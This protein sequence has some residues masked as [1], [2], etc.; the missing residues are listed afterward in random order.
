MF[1]MSDHDL[2][3]LH[4]ATLFTHNQRGD[5]VTVNDS[6]MAPAP[7]FFMGITRHGAVRRFRDDVDNATRAALSELAD[8]HL[9]ALGALDVLE[10]LAEFHALL[11]QSAPVQRTWAGPAFQCSIRFNHPAG[12]ALIG[13]KTPAF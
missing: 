11:T 9:S 2:M 10:H 3:R 6:G 1:A 8:R 7:R 13:E 12:V 5:L 4:V